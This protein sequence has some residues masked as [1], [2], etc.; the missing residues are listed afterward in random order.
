[1]SVTKVPVLHK[2]TSLPTNVQIRI[3]RSLKLYLAPVVTDG[4]SIDASI[5][6]KCRC[7]DGSCLL[8]E[9]LQLLLRVLV[10]ERKSTIR[11]C[12]RKSAKDRVERNGID[13]ID[14]CIRRRRCSIAM[15]LERKVSSEENENCVRSYVVFFPSTP[16]KKFFRSKH[17]GCP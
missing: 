3:I 1:M 10:P 15:A 13:C 12:S 7:R 9:D 2:E 8:V 11:S 14:G 5:S 6:V 16:E 4:V 17:T